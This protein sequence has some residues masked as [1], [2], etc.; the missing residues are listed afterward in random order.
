M[1]TSAARSTWQRGP[2]RQRQLAEDARLLP[3]GLLDRLT[4]AAH[5]DQDTCSARASL[6]CSRG[7][8]R[9]GVPVL[10]RPA[11]GSSERACAHS[12]RYSS[13][14]PGT[15]PQPDHAASVRC[16][17]TVGSRRC[18]SRS[19]RSRRAARFASTP[20]RSP[21]GASCSPAA[22]ENATRRP[23]RESGADPRRTGGLPP[24][25]ASPPP[26]LAGSA[27][28]STFSTPP[29]DVRLARSRVSRWPGI[30]FSR[31]SSPPAR[32]T[33]TSVT[34][35]RSPRGQRQTRCS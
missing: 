21:L 13:N 18:C 29:S 22:G 26:A 25:V 17:S 4:E 3:K 20:A 1:R 16:S 27:R 32:G 2:T 15:A 6:T 23:R 9:R 35:R 5:D 24:P 14:T 30:A 31:R 34:Q 10:A 8:P 28:P 7:A 33:A 19:R 12:S 11:P